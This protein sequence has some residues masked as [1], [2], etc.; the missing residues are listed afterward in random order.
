MRELTTIGSLGGGG[1]M[2]R[3]RNTRST[4]TR[5]YNLRGIGSLG[6]LGWIGQTN[7]AFEAPNAA[8]ILAEPPGDALSNA[9]SAML[10]HFE[11]A[12]VPSEHQ[13]DTFVLAWQQAYNRDPASWAGLRMKLGEDGG[14]GQNS[15]DTAAVLATAVGSPAAPPV[16]TSSSSVPYAGAASGGG[17]VLTLPTIIVHGGGT[18]PASPAKPLALATTETHTGLKWA[19]GLGLAAG[20]AWLAHRMMKKRR[21]RRRGRTRTST[22]I[23]LG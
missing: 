8:D 11:T 4:G 21:G 19:V 15:H 6:D 17:G 1:M 22:A 18:T 7:A 14:Y 9:T 16:N 23:V 2:R 3:Q 13:S 12:G 5:V 20:L 10:D